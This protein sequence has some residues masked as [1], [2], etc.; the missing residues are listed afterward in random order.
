MEIREVSR[1]VHAS[2]RKIFMDE[3]LLNAV[4]SIQQD[5]HSGAVE[6]ANRAASLIMQFCDE[7]H[8]DD[9]AHFNAELAALCRQLMAA[10]PSM[11]SLINLCNDVLWAAKREGV[12][13]V[14]GQ[15]Q[16]ATVPQAASN[17]ALR[18]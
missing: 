13:Y 2:W 10:Q 1:V 16:R 18:F 7:S 5:A 15:P 11:A 4:A 9:D 12:I 14:H 8:G 6:L 3:T 17:A